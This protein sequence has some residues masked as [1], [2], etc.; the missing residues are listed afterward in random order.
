MIAKLRWR[1]IRVSMFSVICV[2]G[3]ILGAINLSVYLRN[4]E[5][6]DAVLDLLIEHSGT[7]PTEA[8]NELPA[9]HTDWLSQEAPYDT[10]FFWVVLGRGGETLEVETGNISAISTEQAVD[11]A[12][13]LASGGH[14]RGYIDEYR[15]AVEPVVNGTLVMLLYNGRE[16][17]AFRSFYTLSIT[18]SGIGILTIF[19]WFYLVQTCHR[20]DCRK[21]QQA[22]ELHYRCRTRNQDT[23]DDY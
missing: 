19:F 2:L 1:F 13:S 22:K 12:H 20:A 16:M 5:R 23:A 7:F 15:Y 8:A 18:I 10:R 21:L 6:A 14:N 3:V 4:T 17:A 11:I 9:I